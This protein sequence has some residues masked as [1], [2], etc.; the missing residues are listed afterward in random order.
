MVIEADLRFAFE[1]ADIAAETSLRA[2]RA[3]EFQTEVKLDGSVVTDVDRRVESVLR[4]MVTERHPG[5]AVVG[6]EFGGTSNSGRCWYLDPIDGTYAFVEGTDRWST[7]VALAE[8]E[9]VRVGVVDFPARRRRFWASRGAGAF[10]DGTPMRVSAVARL[11]DATV[12]D[13]YRHNIE[14]Q[15]P[16]HPLVKLAFLCSGVH[17]HEGHSMLVV[18]DGRADAAI[19]S[20]GGPWDYAPLVVIVEEAGGR[21][22]NLSGEDRFDSGSLLATNGQIHSQILDALRH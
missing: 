7:L 1:L 13:D 8:D 15:T 3:Q 2:F 9:S 16:G 12:C 11:G 5:D 6:E 19:G 21:T 10:G 18:A 22:S 17:P 14:H 4:D 20:G